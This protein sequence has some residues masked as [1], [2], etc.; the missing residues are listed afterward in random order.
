MA[1]RK[2]VGRQEEEKRGGG[3]KRKES[4]E[5]GCI[6]DEGGGGRGEGGGS[7]GGGGGGAKSSRGE[8]STVLHVWQYTVCPCCKHDGRHSLRS[9]DSRFF[10]R[11][12]L[13][14]VQPKDGTQLV[15]H[16][17][18]GDT[19]TKQMASSGIT[20]PNS[21]AQKYTSTPKEGN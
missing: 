6:G 10:R 4:G 12:A 19:N 8:F 21:T 18:D 13:L 1:K 17:Q 16:K 3:R 15:T 9:A 7:G 5:Y 20:V 14:L 11:E 2:K